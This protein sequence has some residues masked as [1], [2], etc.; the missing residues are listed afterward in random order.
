MIGNLVRDCL[1][2]TIGPLQVEC[3]DLLTSRVGEIDVILAAADFCREALPMLIER[4]DNLLVPTDRTAQSTVVTTSHLKT[5]GLQ[6]VLAAQV[7][8]MATSGI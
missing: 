3:F 5:G 4:F 6:G 8:Y 1:E 7:H 2:R